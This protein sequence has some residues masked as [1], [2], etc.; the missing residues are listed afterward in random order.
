MGS[1]GISETEWSKSGQHTSFTDLDL[2]ENGVKRMIATGKALVGPD[3]MIVPEFIEKIF[4]SP[5]KRAH[6]TLELLMQDH[7]GE[8]A[9]LD[10][11]TT[12]DARE[13]DYGDYEGMKTADIRALRK[14]RGLDKDHDWSIWRD[15]CEGGE[16]PADITERLD[17]LIAKIVEI[18]R[19][20]IKERRCSEVIVV[21]HGHILRSFVLRWLKRPIED[22][23]SLILEAGGVGVLSYEHNSCEEPAIFLGGAFHVPDV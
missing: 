12:D 3:R 21:A 23:P 9:K 16:S 20:A 4:V 14:S 8:L 22:N 10:V 15:G 11:E 7:K 13:W 1:N 5:R 6:H 18:H 17:R 2:T 19:K